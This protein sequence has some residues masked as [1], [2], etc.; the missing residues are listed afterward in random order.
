MNS[1]KLKAIARHALAA[2]FLIGSLVYL[3]NG[4]D[5]PRL[6]DSFARF[7]PSLLL[8]AF[9]LSLLAYTVLALRLN[10]LARGVPGFPV[11]IQSVLLA[12][13]MNNLL[14]AKAGEAA[15]VVHLTKAG[16]L[17]PGR[18]LGIVFQERIFD[19]FSVLLFALPAAAYSK[20]LAAPLALAPAAGLAI[21][22][23]F[24]LRWFPRWVNRLFK[25]FPWPRLRRFAREAA[26]LIR[27]NLRM[28]FLPGLAGYSILLWLVYWIYFYLVI[29]VI[30]G[31]QLTAPQVLTVYIIGLLGYALPSAPGGVGV[32]EAAMVFGLSLFG[33]DK[34]DAL[35]VAVVIHMMQFIPTT[36]AGLVVAYRTGTTTDSITRKYSSMERSDPRRS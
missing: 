7:N 13:G 20:H 31:M 15:K 33:V 24:I 10:Y 6:L 32:F 4:L 30:A 3:L 8:A 22:G 27:G 21:L 16:G 14:P 17:S 1:E 11:T 18:S 19:L 34:T 9:A 35:A 28:N 25:L 29:V 5:F 12:L 2:I 23:L 36:A 26:R